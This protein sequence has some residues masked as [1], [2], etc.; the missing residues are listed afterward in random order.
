MLTVQLEL[1]DILMNLLQSPNTGIY[2]IL[3]AAVT[4][5]AAII[6]ALINIIPK[7]R[8]K[9]A[10]GRAKL[11]DSNELEL[12]NMLELGIELARLQYSAYHPWEDYQGMNFEGRKQ[13]IKK[14][15][16]QLKLKAS[17]PLHR[18]ILKL[19]EKFLEWIFRTGGSFIDTYITPAS[20]LQEYYR[21]QMKIYVDRGFFDIG[22]YLGNLEYH[23]VP[24]KTYSGRHLDER[25][26]S[27]VE[28][29]GQAFISNR[30][31]LSLRL[32]EYDLEDLVE[33]LP[34]AHVKE[35]NYYVAIGSVDELIARTKK[36]VRKKEHNRD[37][38]NLPIKDL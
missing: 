5:I 37:T 10:A 30:Q 31:Q 6:V 22:T 1:K 18:R 21:S 28:H 24:L 7:L 3:A 2:A 19:S 17:F 25:Q 8:K 15:A 36:A 11:W 38:D 27:H 20:D 13:L 23:F 9:A 32:I 26:A 4:A 33:Y 34:E 29:F 14:I 12:L 35:S 16:K